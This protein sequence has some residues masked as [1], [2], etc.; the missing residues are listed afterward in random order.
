MRQFRPATPPRCD[1]ARHTLA[2][3]PPLR[4]SRCVLA[5]A[6]LLLAGS[7]LQARGLWLDPGRSLPAL[8]TAAVEH[9]TPEPWLRRGPTGLELA[10]SRGGADRNDAMARA[11]AL[12]SRGDYPGAIALWTEVLS[13][14]PSSR[15]RHQ[16]LISRSKAYLI[17]GQPLLA[18]ADLDACRFQPNETQAL[19]ELWLLKG[20][21][22]L[23]NKQYSEAVAA[24][25]QAEKLQPANP[26]L[27]SNRAVAYQSMG[28]LA[29]ARAD[30]QA[31]IR[32]QPN[33]SNYFNLAVLERQSGNAASCYNLLSQIIARSQPYAKLYV[34]RGLCA[35]QLNQHD[36]AI[37][38]MLKALKMDANNIEALRQIGLSLAAQNQIEPAKHYLLKASSLML[39][40]GQIDEYQ[41]LLA[42]M[43]ALGKR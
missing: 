18:L 32:L 35:A 8:G 30:L 13:A 19:A 23:Q 12:F 9:P 6:A 20:S 28:N 37:A 5:A 21:A 3:S 1:A 11:A 34:Q 17:V 26:V 27:L 7:P 10:Q 41:K 43:A 38:D 31:A 25:A 2:S 22:L 33:L 39:A 42:L 29:A 24:F 15:L 16:A 14:N 4:L 36:A 40:N